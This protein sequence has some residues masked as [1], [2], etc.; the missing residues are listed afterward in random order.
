MY[1][2]IGRIHFVGIGGTGMNGIA[3]VL[4][5]LGYKVSGS[6]L[7]TGPVTERLAARGGIIH[8][9]HDAAH[10]KGA[11]VVVTSTAVG[12][13]NPEVRRA[14]ELGIPVIPR[15][16]MLA[17][18]MRAKYAV[19]V[20]GAHGK[21]TTTSMVAGV[22]TA[23]ELDPTVVVGGRVLSL[24]SNARTG[25]GQFLVAEADE[26]DGSFLKLLPSIAVITN[27]DA[28]HLDHWT[29]GIDQIRAAFVEF[30]NKV[31][32]YGV[33]V[34]CL[35]DPEVLKAM[36]MITRRVKTYGLAVQ[37]DF[38]ARDVRMTREGGT[39]RLDYELVERRQS[40][41]RIQLSV[42][43]RH[44]VLNSLAAAAVG[45]ELEVPFEKIQA[46]LASF[47]GV[48]RRLEL[49]GMAGDIR[50][51]DDYGHHPTEVLVVLATLKEAFAGRV[52]VV[53]QPHR[54]TRTR[55]FHEAFGRAF[56]DADCLFLLPVYAAGEAPIPGAD[57]ASIAQAAR[58]AGHKAVELVAGADE[59]V[60]K[61]AREARPG[62]VILTLGAGDVTKL[63][64]RIV[65]RLGGG[66]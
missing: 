18:L 9:G 23:G 19:A 53:F 12:V 8:Q 65:A 44:N 45:R 40:L 26:S 39:A 25:Q 63:G 22:L 41:G 27:I 66:A 37:A 36:P 4:L 55:D 13:D 16:E 29:G 64:E 42:S 59:A 50:V 32:F 34:V 57:A 33:A 1:G 15:A 62:D 24:G 5:D 6:D 58:G 30:A 14:R 49:K 11:S 51:I 52:L 54:Y 35:D 48:A 17:E 61:V 7:A 10:V 3:E 56:H 47:T 28:E 20:A 43:G 46:G 38:V 2:R 31:P 21:T 60:E